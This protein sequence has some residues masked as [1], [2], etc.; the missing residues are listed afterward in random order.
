MSKLKSVVKDT[1]EY[2]K[3][4][5]FIL[6]TIIDAQIAHLKKLGRQS[7]PKLVNALKY[8]KK[9]IRNLED[10]EYSDLIRYKYES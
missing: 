8:K 10:S 1:F 6:L 3:E 5:W 4:D 9:L 7:I 2:N